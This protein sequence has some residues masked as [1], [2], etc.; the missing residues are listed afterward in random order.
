MADQNQLNE[1]RYQTKELKQ[2]K[3]VLAIMTKV[4]ILKACYGIGKERMDDRDWSDLK[5]TIKTGSR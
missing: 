3:W 5:M 4:Q 1:M 2:I